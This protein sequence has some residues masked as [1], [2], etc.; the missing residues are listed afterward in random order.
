MGILKK[1]SIVF[2]IIAAGMLSYP[3]LHYFGLDNEKEAAK[4]FD[5]AK[6]ATEQYIQLDR[7][8]VDE[9]FGVADSSPAPT[10]APVPGTVKEIPVE[11]KMMAPYQPAPK[12]DDK[13]ELG[14]VVGGLERYAADK[15]STKWL[16][17]PPGF[18]MLKTFNFMLY[19]QYKPITKDVEDTFNTIHGNL[20]L[21]L[22]PFTLVRKPNRVLV[23]LFGDSKSYSQFTR[24]AE[25]SGA[26][27]DLE[28]STLYILENSGF[29]PITIHEMTHLYFDGFFFPYKMPLWIS[30][31]MA[32]YMQV[33]SS[34]EKPLWL[35]GALSKI[36][37]GEAIPMDQ[38]TSVTSLSGYAADDVYMWYTQAYSIVEY[39][40]NEHK[41]D[42]FYKF[43]INLKDGMPP[44][45]AL[46]RAYGLPFTRYSVLE[47][48]WM[49][50]VQE[51]SSQRVNSMNIAGAAN[52]K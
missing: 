13:E 32:M 19:R 47:N 48:V 4:L 9:I 1:L 28:K 8:K 14:K 7:K 5:K 44:A 39:M 33:K 23:M 46:Y 25:W 37:R 18:N 42:D 15:M 26:S 29:Y 27:C 50:N 12:A 21:D 40:L 10:P 3:V 49:Y 35:L 52:G 24:R 11:R 16:P 30:E 6:K 41:R 36:E 2:W 31:G 17:P 20:M 45:Q 34:G 22:V 51:K 38:F 43:C